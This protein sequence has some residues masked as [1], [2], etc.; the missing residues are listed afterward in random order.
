MIAD[1][2]GHNLN[3]HTDVYCLQSSLLERTK[4][5]SILLA[6]EN[7]HMQKF[8][9]KALSDLNCDQLP[10]PIDYMDDWNNTEDKDGDD[11][12]VGETGEDSNTANASK[13]I[14]ENADAGN[15]T[16]YSS[17]DDDMLVQF[18]EQKATKD[19]WTQT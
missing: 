16:D 14:D 1:Q 13:E 2:L 6:V 19:M 10:L 11:P 9:G 17:E 5:A 3:I 18:P 8:R 12:S 15:R 4:V 7:G